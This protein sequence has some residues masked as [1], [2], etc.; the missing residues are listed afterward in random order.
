MSFHTVLSANLNQVLP[1][2]VYVIVRDGSSGQMITTST[3][4]GILPA[5][6]PATSNLAF[7]LVVPNLLPGVYVATFSADSA[8]GTIS[9]GAWT[10]QFTVNAKTYPLG[11][12]TLTIVSATS[13]PVGVCPSWCTDISY[14]NN[15]NASISIVVSLVFHNSIGQTVYMERVAEWIAKGQ[16]ASAHLSVSGFTTGTYSAEI[17]AISSSGVAL[18][19]QSVVAVAL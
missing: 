10:I 1:V 19:S 4:S 5:S 11:I 15:A 2:F 17:F 8:D 9:S 6:Y 13:P 18:S 12:Q 16:T 3:A 14:Q 7:I